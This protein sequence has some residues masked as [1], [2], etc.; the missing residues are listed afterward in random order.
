MLR[1]SNPLGLTQPNGDLM[2]RGFAIKR[3]RFIREM[4]RRNIPD[5]AALARTVG[6]HKTTAWRVLNGQSRPG[7]DFVNRV[8][9]AWGMEFHDLFDDPRTKRSRT[10]A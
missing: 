7:P 1:R 2:T 3:G 10:A 6:V 9:D 4:K 5:A 8:L